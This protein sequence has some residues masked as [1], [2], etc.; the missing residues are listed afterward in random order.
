MVETLASDG[1]ADIDV[2]CNIDLFSIKSNPMS[3]NSLLLNF[4]DI[5]MSSTTSLWPHQDHLLKGDGMFMVPE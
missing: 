5:A 4:T 1:R 3:M 2:H